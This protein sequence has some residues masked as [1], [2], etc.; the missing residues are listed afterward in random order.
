MRNIISSFPIPCPLSLYFLL[1]FP[2]SLF[3]FLILSC[4]YH[5]PTLYQRLLT[6]TSSI[7]SCTFS[8]VTAPVNLK[9]ITIS[10]YPLSPPYPY[11]T[12]RTL[13][14]PYRTAP[15]LVLSIQAVSSKLLPSVLHVLEKS[16]YSEGLVQLGHSPEVY[17]TALTNLNLIQ[18]AIFLYP[19]FPSLPHLLDIWN[20]HCCRLR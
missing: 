14:V 2:S 7:L 10:K 5:K 19:S 3:Y 1:L 16:L 11:P 15:Y 20:I 12:L 8:N 4:P 18:I 17:N 6:D 9:Y 13:T